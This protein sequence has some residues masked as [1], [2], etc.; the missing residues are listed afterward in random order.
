MY[1]ILARQM[2]VPNMHLLKV[3]SPDIARKAQAG[4]FVLLIPDENGE[5]IP[6]TI[7][8]WDVKEGSV[9][10]IFVEVG[11]TTR[12]LARLNS[13]DSIETYVGPLGLPT[14]IKNFGTV[15]CTG[16]CYGIG[17]IYPIVTSLKEAG[18]H[19]ISVIEA[20]S[21]FLLYWED[22]LKSA[23]D[24]LYIVTR[25]GSCGIKGH[26][27]HVLEE[28]LKEKKVDRVIAM[29]CTYMMMLSAESSRPFEVKT[30]VSLNPVMLDG[31]GMCG[32]CRISVDGET[33]FAC[34]DGPEFDGHKVDWK[35]LFSRKEVYITE[36]RDSLRIYECQ[37]YPVDIANRKINLIRHKEDVGV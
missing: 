2:L 11:A 29:G 10:S 16:G 14:E 9:T 19:V 35:E 34:V 13:G 21:S 22:K 24:Q 20:R 37:S 32:I 31:T 3:Y 27:A 1:K 23:S 17:G 36:E 15:L 28:I 18:N 5:R 30:V 6:L 8:D 4:Q 26:V 7:S 25:D 33:K 12:K